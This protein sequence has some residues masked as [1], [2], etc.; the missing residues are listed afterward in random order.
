M[1]ITEILDF[2]SWMT[3]LFAFLTRMDSLSLAAWSFTRSFSLAAFLPICISLQLEC[4][5]NK[6]MFIFVKLRAWFNSSQKMVTWFFGKV[7]KTVLLIELMSLS[8]CF[9]LKINFEMWTHFSCESFATF[10]ITLGRSK[11]SKVCLKINLGQP[12]IAVKLRS[13]SIKI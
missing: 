2:D 8:F 13:S 11:T 10:L 3:F 5:I 12:L 6:V 9:P 7:L 4:K 1:K